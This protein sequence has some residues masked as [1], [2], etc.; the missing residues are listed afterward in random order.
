MDIPVTLREAYENF[1]KM[2]SKKNKEYIKTCSEED[3]MHMHLGLGLW[4]RNN[5]IYP[6]NDRIAKVFADKGITDSDDIS[7]YIIRGYNLYLNGQ[8]CDIDDIVE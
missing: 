8:P 7:R 5:W 1:N 6:A 3:F 4:I 2:L